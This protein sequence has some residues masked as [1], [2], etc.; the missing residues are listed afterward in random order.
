M[1]LSGT[2]KEF[3]TVDRMLASHARTLSLDAFSVTWMKTT[4]HL[5]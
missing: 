3:E 4:A 2:N 1:T 5:S